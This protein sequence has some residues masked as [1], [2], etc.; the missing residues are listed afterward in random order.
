MSAQTVNKQS[1]LAHRRTVKSKKPFFLRQDAHKKKKLSQNWRRPKGSDSKMRVQL[2]GY[3]RVVTVGWKSPG[4]VRSLTRAGL[5]EVA[6]SSVDKL[7]LLDPAVHAVTVSSQVGLKKRI[8]ILGEANKRKFSVTNFKDPAAFIATAQQK[9]EEARKL[10][11]DVKKSRESKHEETKKA[12]ETKKEKE[13]KEKESKEKESKEEKKTADEN[14]D[15]KKEP[16][17]ADKQ[18]SEQEQKA[19]EE[20]KEKD[21]ILT[22]RN[23]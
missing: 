22:S 1:L 16:A 18:A 12:A 6:I 15:E 14:A 19:V 5:A 8:A 2:R 10:K 3:R 13:A 9:R 17:A 7:A 11:Q 23:Q 4:A 21:K 20:K